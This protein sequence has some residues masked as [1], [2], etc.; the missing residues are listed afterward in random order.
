VI[1]FGVTPEDLNEASCYFVI[2][3]GGKP[4]GDHIVEKAEKGLIALHSLR[5]AL[6]SGS[7]VNDRLQGD[8]RQSK[9]HVAN[10]MRFDI[11][12]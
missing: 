2:T 1:S 3:A 5:C 9:W 4:F 12:F 11:R 7:K 10:I 6:H 8:L